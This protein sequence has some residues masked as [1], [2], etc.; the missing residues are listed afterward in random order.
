MRTYAKP[1]PAG[2][3]VDTGHIR[4]TDARDAHSIGGGAVV[5]V[6]ASTAFA[7]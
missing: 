6:V 2:R 5:T 7:C 1:L 4:K 3:L